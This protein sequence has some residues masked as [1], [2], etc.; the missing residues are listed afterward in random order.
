MSL[1]KLRVLLADDNTHMRAIVMTLLQSFGVGEIIEAGDGGEALKV[2]GGWSPDIAIVDFKMAPMNGVEFTRRVRHGPDSRDPYLPIIMMTGHS[3]RASVE[4]ARDAGV[5]E[6]IV[7]PLTART[8]LHRIHAVI[9]KPRPF[10]QTETYFGPDRRRRDDG[11]YAG[12]RRRAGETGARRPAA[13]DRS[14]V[15]I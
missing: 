14:S 11:A 6:F 9:H 5:T 15:M 8:L 10:I 3:G 13:Q 12:P 7:K 1:G 2:L 4:Q